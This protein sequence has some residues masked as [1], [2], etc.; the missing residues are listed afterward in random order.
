M[1]LKKLILHGFKS[2]ADR[3]EFVFDSAITGIVG[4]NGCGKSNVVDGFK[5]VLGEQ[6]AKSLRG[7]AM[8]D[9]IFN[10]SGGRKPAG[11]AEVVLVFD[12]PKREDGSRH[13][14]VDLDEVSVGRRLYRDGTSEYTQNNGV[15]RLKDIRELFMDTGV[16][17]DA[18]SVIEQGRV[19]ALLEANPEERR[20]IFEEAAGISKFKQ[21]KKEAQRKLEKVD[22]NLVRVHD[23]VEEVD[24]RLRS[25]KVQAGKARNYQEYAVRLNELRLSYA[26]REYHTL[27]A[28]VA[29]LQTGHDDGKFRQEDAFANL[30]RSQNAL[31]EK[32][33]SFEVLNRAKQ[34]AEHQVVETRAGVQSAVQRQNWAEEQLQQITHQ[35]EQFEADREAASERLAEV[36]STLESESQSLTELTAE[37]SDRRSQIEEHQD[38]HRE[39][40]LQL[41]NVGRE[42][43]QNKSG[44]LDL[45]RRTAT[46]NSRLGAIEIERKNIASQQGRLAERQAVITQEQSAIAG[47]QADHQSRLTDV[48]EHLAERQRELELKREA[49]QQLGKQI[50]TASDNLGAAREHRSGLL[51]RQK[52]L[53]D[54]EAKREGVS[55]GVKAVLRQRGPGE[56]FAFVRGLVAD[57]IRV[58]VEHATLIEAALDGRDQWLVTDEA[59]AVSRL[60][61]VADDLEGR[62]NLL[63]TTE[64][65]PANIPAHNWNAH[66]HLIR[67]A[68]DLVR[69]EPSDAN[70]AD[71]LLGRTIAVDNLSAAGEL[72]KLA[73]AGWRFVTYAGEVVETDGTVRAGPLTAAMGLISRRSELEVLDQQL[74]DVEARI[75]GL[76]E[77]LQHTNAA[78]KSIEEEQNALRNEIYKANTTKVELTSKLQQF[79]DKAA[80]LGRELPLVEREL[81]NYESQIEKLAAE[82]E[83]VTRQRESLEAEQAEKQR[84]VEDLT[85]RHRELS[86]QMKV[87]AETL[88][89]ARVELGQI[90]EKQLAC[91]QHVGRLTAQRAELSQQVERLARSAEGL[92]HRRGQVEQELVSAKEAEAMLAEQLGTLIAQAQELAS[93]AR[94]AGEAMRTFQADVERYRSSY[95]EIEQSMHALEV[96]LGQSRV[97]L[98][99]VIS[100][101]QE[102]LQIDIVER[103]KQI[104]TPKEEVEV[105]PVVEEAVASAEQSQEAVEAAPVE[106]EETITGAMPSLYGDDAGVVKPAQAVA[107]P[108][109]QPVAA[110]KPDEPQYNFLDGDID[111]DE[112]AAEIKELKEKIQRLGNVN[113]DAIAEMDEL[114]Q[115][116]TFLTQQVSDLTES[117]RQLEELIDRINVESGL[118]F[119][120]TLTAVREH[121]Q[122]MFR[123]LFGG[124]KADIFLETE[125]EL[126]P[127]MGPDGV[128]LPP[129]KKKVDPLEAGIEILA[130]PPGKKPATINQLSGGE[131]A[132]TC[133]AL[134]MSIFKS[135][136][137]PF[138]IL[139]EVDAPL[140]EAN[141]QRFGLII[142]EFLSI[143]QFIVITHHKRTMQICD[144][145]YGV[146]MQEQGVSKRVAVKFDQVDNQGRISETAAA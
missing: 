4:P 34:Q 46:T 36:E 67:F 127:V 26:L 75:V 123:K 118:R 117:K 71:H 114:E 3:T 101:T 128:L 124:G 48:T 142:Q 40:Q 136:P 88:T 130:H 15:A 22:Q 59:G 52:L 25:V 57:F 109:P 120:Q 115:R 100:R 139:D 141:N 86:E 108:T 28:Q 105:E 30:S 90:Q 121:F 135:K 58:D 62:V 113:I 68:S 29:E 103:Y 83:N 134:L 45:M 27:H 126:K 106:E 76:S 98:E 70:L 39:G 72:R 55:E 132:M 140:D 96:S 87:L 44:I 129:E 41:N 10:G 20:L 14:P 54:L 89:A 93:Q 119:E 77:Q 8:M 47:Q 21:R 81:A 92:V 78:A 64:L 12:N 7:D 35:Q 104:T 74:I 91:Q 133:I 53:K 143:S 2:F 112:I 19:A 107:V 13:L 66:N 18:Y 69:F 94:E 73:P 79:A 111:W 56:P 50:A 11:L 23:I 95:A 17:V 131:K 65:P 60:T 84:M 138:C 122:G 33:E 51:S 38:A 31:A 137:S 85:V 99:T 125:I 146:T 24:R 145:L 116:S 42:I 32:R 5:W 1:R 110:R 16:G 37:L 82:E 102:E 63:C 80:S 6:S 97:R 49:L 61:A 144:V 43:E 9:V